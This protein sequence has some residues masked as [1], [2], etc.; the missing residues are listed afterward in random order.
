M[1]VKQ[2]NC[3][4]IPIP[5]E[6]LEIMGDFQG[7]LKSQLLRSLSAK[8]KGR[9]PFCTEMTAATNTSIK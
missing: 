2:R 8:S 1:K 6:V 9:V 3:Q 7:N 5:K 4:K